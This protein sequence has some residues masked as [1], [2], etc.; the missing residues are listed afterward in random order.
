MKLPRLRLVR[1]F[2]AAFFLMLFSALAALPLQAQGT[3][4]R[5][6]NSDWQFRAVGN[7]DKTEVK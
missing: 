7:T 5:L 1:L 4:S 6:L 3:S 2:G